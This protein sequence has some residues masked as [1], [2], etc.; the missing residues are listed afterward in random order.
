MSHHQSQHDFGDE[1]LK[2]HLGQSFC[3]TYTQWKIP[4]KVEVWSK[5]LYYRGRLVD[6]FWR[7]DWLRGKQPLLPESCSLKSR[8]VSREGSCNEIYFFCL[9]GG[10][11][12]AIY[13]PLYFN[14]QLIH[15]SWL[16]RTNIADVQITLPWACRGQFIN[17]WKRHFPSPAYFSNWD[18]S[19]HY[20]GD[21]ST[22]SA[23]SR[24]I[25]VSNASK[26]FIRFLEK[27]KFM[28]VC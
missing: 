21:E 7:G 23:S 25:V 14:N 6:Q 26:Y 12:C 22:T 27:D 4:Q 13:R 10:G 16:S 1:I 24:V 2:Y 20:T 18:W 3:K 8:E 19:L 28:Q 17:W 11:V 15:I 9:C 5:A